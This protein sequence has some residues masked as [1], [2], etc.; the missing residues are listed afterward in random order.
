MVREEVA[1]SDDPLPDP[2]LSLS[3]IRACMQSCISYENIGK[4]EEGLEG[5]E[6]E[7][8][9]GERQ[10][11]RRQKCWAPRISHSFSFCN[12]LV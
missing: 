2:P 8:K 9:A 4:E 3:A 5:G 7:E 6:G 11:V 12:V 10:A 1:P